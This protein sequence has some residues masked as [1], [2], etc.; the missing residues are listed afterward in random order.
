MA[1]FASVF[2]DENLG[3]VETF[4]ARHNDDTYVNNILQNE[5]YVN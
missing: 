1:F 4:P 2:T 5:T 3:D